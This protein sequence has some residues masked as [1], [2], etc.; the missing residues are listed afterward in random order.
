MLLLFLLD[1]V[2]FAC[3]I[4][5]FYYLLFLPFIYFFI[6]SNLISYVVIIIQVNLGMGLKQLRLITVVFGFQ[7]RIFI[8]RFLRFVCCIVSDQRCLRVYSQS[9]LLDRMLRLFSYQTCPL[10]INTIHKM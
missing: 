4:F 8:A 7:N 6:D 3:F 2:L 10:I 1:L 9:N 5:L